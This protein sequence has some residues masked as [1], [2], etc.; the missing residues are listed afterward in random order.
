MKENEDLTLEQMR[1]QA[2][3]LKEKLAKEKL[4]NEDMV[5]K[6]IMKEANDIIWE[7]KLNSLPIVDENDHLMYFVFRKDYAT[8]KKNPLEL[9]DMN[10][11]MMHSS[12]GSIWKS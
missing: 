2:A 6:A 9:L 11:Y 7:H 4:V 3:I 10:E 8:H 12:T 1:A 5:K